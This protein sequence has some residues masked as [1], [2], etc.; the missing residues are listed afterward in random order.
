MN[1]RIVQVL[2]LLAIV[3][4]A[5]CS[6]NSMTQSLVP[7]TQ[8]L[9]EQN[10]MPPD[11]LIGAASGDVPFLTMNPSRRLCALP[12]SPDR[13]EC[14]S[15]VRTDFKP[16]LQ[17]NPQA[18]GD[19]EG[20]PFGS[21]Q[22]YC[23]I[24]LQEAYKLPS[25]SRG[26]N[27]VV[28][29][30]DAYG[31]HNAA[32]DLAFYRKTMGLPAC[33]LESKCLR[34][35]NQE[36]RPSPLPGEPPANDDWKGEES[37]DLDMVSAICPYCKII[38]VQT[39]NNDTNNLYTGVK[40][41]GN[42][43][44][45]YIGASWGSGPEGGDNSIFHQPGVVISAAAGDNGG[46][47]RYQGGP[48]QPCTYTYVVCVG[49]THLVRANN[50]RGWSETVWNDWTFDYCGSGN[51]PCGATGSACSTKI[52][53]PAWQTDDGCHMRS[54]ADT[55]ATASLRSPV[56]VYNSEEGSPKCSPPNC[57]W[58]FGGTSASTQ[59]ISAVFALGGNAN[60]GQGASYVW[61]H[62]TGNLYDVTKGNNID[63]QLGVTCAS[64]VS[65]ICTAKFGFDGPT[66]LGTPHGIGAF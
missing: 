54:A 40:T 39:N 19:A 63:P 57:F 64:H 31:Y 5:A 10:A 45:K 28:A 11:A 53:K 4:L 30:V 12:E 65:Y 6:S 18:G 66:G 23:P 61:K 25:L 37:L 29:I 50:T 1:R 46:G 58:A 3:V 27:R 13:M 42:L 17:E 9:A 8:S 55:S 14:L 36:G 34:I 47:G 62:K 41:A 35:V 52:A 22:G 60:F 15:S 16:A 56:I 20:C 59:I 43:H 7:Q 38:L 49:G 21:N 32:S 48:I 33:S 24:D 2:P 26:H 51:S 44:A